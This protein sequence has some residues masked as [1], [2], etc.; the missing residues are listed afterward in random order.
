MRLSHV[1][2]TNLPFSMQDLFFTEKALAPSTRVYYTF[3]MRCAPWHAILAHPG[4]SPT[5]RTTVLRSFVMR[6]SPAA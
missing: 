3:L 2:V 5:F 1:S 4:L 6:A